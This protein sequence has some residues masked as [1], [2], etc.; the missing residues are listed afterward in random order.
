MALSRQAAVRK[1]ARLFAVG[2]SM[3]V[4]FFSIVLRKAYGLGAMAMTG[5]LSC[6]ANVFHVSWPTAEAGP[7]VRRP[8]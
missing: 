1:L 5:G 2:A 8:H 4:P 7:M 3:S 6:G